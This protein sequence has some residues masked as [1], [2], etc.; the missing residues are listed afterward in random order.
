MNTILV[1]DDK[2][3][4]LTTL[5][6][7]LA[8]DFDKIL[9]LES[10]ETCL[11]VLATED[12]NMVLLDMNFHLGVNTGSEGLF[13][14]EQ[15]KKH[16]PEIPVVLFTAYGDIDI[17]VRGLKM[18][19]ADFVTKPWDNDVLIDKLRSVM[20]KCRQQMKTLDEIEEEHIHRAL[21]KCHGNLSQASEMLGISRQTLY[22]KIKTKKK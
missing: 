3:E 20:A 1:I 4:I 19:A 2:K 8:E 16:H 11:Q 17:A 12:V 10:P 13:W 18:G 14:L 7:L 15:I 22:N 9:T 21:D 5:E 6:Y